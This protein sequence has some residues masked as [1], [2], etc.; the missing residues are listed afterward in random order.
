MLI[1]SRLRRATPASVAVAHVAASVQ[2]QH[3]ARAARTRAVSFFF[4]A[5]FFLPSPSFHGVFLPLLREV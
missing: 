1:D 3:R 5:A 2:V 4:S